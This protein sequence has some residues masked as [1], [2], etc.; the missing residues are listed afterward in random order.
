MSNKDIYK[1]LQKCDFFCYTS[2][3]IESFSL[4]LWEAAINGCI[5]ITFKLGALDEIEK[6]D[7][8]VIENKNMELYINKLLE[9]M[10][11]NTLK[12][13]IRNNILNKCSEY[14]YDWDYISSLWYDIVI[15]H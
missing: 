5:P 4:S 11:N 7:G 9:I 15:L 10:K 8:I 1:I 12:E 13:N 14:C 3:I 2:N 6:V